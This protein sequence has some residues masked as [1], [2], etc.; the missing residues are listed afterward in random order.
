MD[1]SLEQIAGVAAAVQEEDGGDASSSTN[2]KHRL[3][4]EL[5][6]TAMPQATE[7]FLLLLKNKFVGSTLHR[8]EKNVGLLGGLVVTDGEGNGNSK[9]IGQCHASLRMPTSP[10]NMDIASER[11]VLHHLPG[12]I[13]MV[14]PKVGEIDS[15]FLLTSTECP[16]LDGGNAI[17]IGRLSKESLEI[18]QHFTSTLITHRGRPTNVILR[19]TECGALGATSATTSTETTTTTSTATAEAAK[20]SMAAGG[21]EYLR[22]IT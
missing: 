8:V 18:V 17:P 1:I 16:H 20:A 5:A 21:A 9:P 2:N 10:T 13:S 14:S 19:I 15:R 11:L 6:T 12:M 4:F 3:T 7:N 22:S